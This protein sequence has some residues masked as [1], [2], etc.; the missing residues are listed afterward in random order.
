MERTNLVGNSTP[1]N[2]FTGIQDNP[3]DPVPYREPEYPIHCPLVPLFT[4][5]G[6]AG[7]KV[8]PNSAERAL[9]YGVSS[10]DAISKY[11]NEY[12]YLSN[13]LM[14]EGNIHATVRVKPRN[15]PAPAN[16]TLWLDVLATKIP[17]Y[18]RNS[19]GSIVKDELGEKVAELDVNDDPILIDG[20]RVKYFT[21]TFPAGMEFG[22]QEINLNGSM[23]DAVDN[24]KKSKLIPILDIAGKDFGEY[25]SNLGFKI[26]PIVG[27]ALKSRFATEGKFLPYEFSLYERPDAVTTGVPIKTLS[28]GTSTTV[29][30]A[31][32]K[33]H[34]YTEAILDVD[35]LVPHNWYNEGPAFPKI[36]YY[37]FDNIHFYYQNLDNVLKQFLETETPH[38][39][40]DAVEWEDGVE[41]ATIDWFDFTADTGIEDEQ[42]LVNWVTLKSSNKEVGYFSIIKDNSVL[43]APTGKTEV[44][45]G[46]DSVIYLQGGGDGTISNEEMEFYISQMMNEYLDSDSRVQSLVTNKESSFYDVGLDKEAKK[47]LANMLAVRPDTIVHWCTHQYSYGDTPMTTDEEYAVALAILA[48]A[49]IFPESEY[50]GTSVARATVIMGSMEDKD[51]PSKKRYTQNYELALILARY[52]GASNGIMKPLYCLDNGRANTVL[53]LGKN[54]TPEYIPD[55][56]KQLVW[57]KGVTYSE[58]YKIN[59]KAF[60]AVRTIHKNEMSVLTSPILLYTNGLCCRIMDDAHKEFAGNE[61]DDNAVFSNMLV[62][63]MEGKI[64]GVVDNGRFDIV[65]DVEFGATGSEA[66]YAYKTWAHIAANLMKTAQVSSVS[67]HIKE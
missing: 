20:F 33:K 16:T 63:Y 28:Y 55:S 5:K 6:P 19:D 29:S 53:T 14:G 25:Y 44:T 45:I 12:T 39:S 50:Y 30:F 62:K 48:R 22:K 58:D 56:Y 3:D 8:Y 34:P 64:K 41:A 65:W 52:L 24:T 37:D 31:K 43:V 36:K 67:T 15:A 9:M 66:K 1:L 47:Q 35:L 42:H 7:K 49:E 17:L 23:V 38:I 60:L 13:I 21:S 40:N 4:K 46:G 61:K 26:A 11:Y 27:S 59:Q 10:F 32:T 51:S 18:K 57:S 2:R 54:Y